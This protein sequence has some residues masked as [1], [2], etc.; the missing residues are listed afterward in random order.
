MMSSIASVAVVVFASTS[1]EQFVV[2]GD[3]PVHTHLGRKLYFFGGGLIRRVGRCNNQT[4]A[5]FAKHHYPIVAAMIQKVLDQEKICSIIVDCLRGVNLNPI[6][7]RTQGS[8]LI[9]MTP[10]MPGNPG[11]V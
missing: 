9:Q 8:R 6:R 5:P 10:K 4:V 11:R 7:W 3:D 2:F 1:L